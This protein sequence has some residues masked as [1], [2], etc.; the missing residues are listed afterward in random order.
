MSKKAKWSIGGGA[1][2]AIIAVVLI[3]QFVVPSSNSSATARFGVP[4]ARAA[5]PIGHIGNGKAA[6]AVENAGSADKYVY[7]VFYRDNDDQLTKVRGL[8]E[9][10]RKK[11]SR[12]SEEIEINV[13]D[14]TEQD[15]VNKFGASRAPM[16]LVLVVAPNGAIM[17]GFPGTQLADDAR[18]VDAVGCKAL[19]QTM[20]ALQQK[21]MV[22]L[23]VQS[24][25]TTDNAGAMRG[26]EDFLKDPKYSATTAVV[27]ADPS[28][29]EDAKFLSKLGIAP[30]PTVA[31]TV[32]LAPPGSIVATFQG[33]TP[34]DKIVAAV[35]AAA[36]PKAGGC[37]PGG[38][39]KGCGPTGGT[40]AAPQTKPMTSPPVQAKPVQ[41]SASSATSATAPTTKQ[42]K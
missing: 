5:E 25:K 28:N 30:N 8:V 2:I 32:L 40:A 16:P 26:V 27:T 35:V 10:A 41:V 42:G 34:K 31:T 21:N 22:A 7:A 20:K 36:A 18:L 11:V 19:E 1:I 12:K 33:A 39:S 14:P 23:C 13:A 37:C 9:S 6:Q 15:I 4:S 17:G 3:L 38:S 29:A 24:R